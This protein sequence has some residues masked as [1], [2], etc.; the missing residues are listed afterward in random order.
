MKLLCSDGI[1]VE[2]PW[3]MLQN[4]SVTLANMVEC[5]TVA[6]SGADS[7]EVPISIIHSPVMELVRE[8]VEHRFHKKDP[9]YVFQRAERLQLLIDLVMAANFL[10]IDALLS[11]VCAYIAAKVQYWVCDDID[12][13]LHQQKMATATVN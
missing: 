13:F 9:S 10:E 2:I 12:V 4:E 3:Q 7:L 5:V 8:Y 1:S 6:E 11:G